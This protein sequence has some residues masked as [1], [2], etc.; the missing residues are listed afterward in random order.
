M[1]FRDFFPDFFTDFFLGE[2]GAPTPTFGDM[3]AVLTGAGSL[4]G[5]LEEPESGP[6]AGSSGGRFIKIYQRAVRE[7]VRAFW[8]RERPESAPARSKKAAKR[9]VAAKKV[10]R[11]AQTTAA[12][13][14]PAPAARETVYGDMSVR[15]AS[16][17]TLT[18]ALDWTDDGEIE[19]ILLALLDE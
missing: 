13:A 10:A 3:A 1:A 15:M 11:K 8:E 18:G 17:R 5:T 4:A 12:P 16:R 7:R 19:R 6:P 9:A 14:A 2:S